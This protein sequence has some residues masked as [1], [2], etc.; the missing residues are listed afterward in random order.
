MTTTESQIRSASEL[1]YDATID[2]LYADGELIGG[3][4]DMTR[5]IMLEL[6]DGEDKNEMSDE[7]LFEAI[8]T[9]ENSDP[10]AE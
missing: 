9:T 4:S 1:V 8:V 2:G 5:E 7:D 10:D 6:C 3:A